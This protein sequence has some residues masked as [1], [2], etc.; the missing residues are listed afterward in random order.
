MSMEVD[1][2]RRRSGKKKCSHSWVTILAK[3]TFFCVRNEATADTI[4][5]GAWDLATRLTVNVP[6]DDSRYAR[7]RYVVNCVVLFGRRGGELRLVLPPGDVPSAHLCVNRVPPPS[8]PGAPACVEFPVT[9]RVQ[10]AHALH[11]STV[12]VVKPACLLRT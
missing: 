5:A 11:H 7:T 9:L 3:P 6:H 12:T 4:E 10:S 1:S 8:P 2:V